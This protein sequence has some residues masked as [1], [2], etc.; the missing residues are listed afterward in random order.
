[1]VHSRSQ[2]CNGRKMQRQAGLAVV[3][4]GRAWKFFI[5]IAGCCVKP[6]CVHARSCGERR[7]TRRFRRP[8]CSP[9]LPWLFPGKMVRIDAPC[10]ERG[11]RIRAEMRDGKV[12]GA[13]P[14]RNDIVG[15]CPGRPPFIVLFLVA[16]VSSNGAECSAGFHDGRPGGG[17]RTFS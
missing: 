3:Q 2:G 9:E 5:A 15:C 7:S 10:L 14:D 8:I 6:A 1:M 11:E 4:W 17:V 16:G 12:V 13:E